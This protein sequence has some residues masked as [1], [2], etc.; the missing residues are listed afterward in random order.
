MRMNMFARPD[1]CDGRA[2]RPT[3]FADD[4]PDGNFVECELV[5]LLDRVV[6]GQVPAR[7]FNVLAPF[8]RPKRDSDIIAGMD[9]DR[10]RGALESLGAARKS[11]R[12]DRCH[13]PMRIA[14]TPLAG[15]C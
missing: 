4:P 9:L 11:H 13:L 8:E 12:R 5:S 15:I 1:R 10:R 2:D 6:D 3:E 7:N 14:S